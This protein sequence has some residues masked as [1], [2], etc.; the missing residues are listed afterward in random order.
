MPTPEHVLFPVVL[1]GRYRYR[2]F[3]LNRFRLPPTAD[4]V[5][6][7][8]TCTPVPPSTDIN[9]MPKETLRIRG[10]CQNNLK[11][12]DLDLPLNELIVVTGVSGS[13][14]SSLAFDTV[15]AEGHSRQ[16]RPKR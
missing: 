15:Y 11:N 12:L 14:K 10:A 8:P 7:C 1:N 13:G 3:L 16:R 5:T 4:P 6:W 2:K 9:S